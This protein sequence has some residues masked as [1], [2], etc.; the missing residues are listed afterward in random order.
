MGGSRRR[1]SQEIL[2]AYCVWAAKSSFHGACLE[3]LCR[4]SDWALKTSVEWER[5]IVMVSNPMVESYFA[6]L[7]TKLADLPRPKREEILRELRAHVWDRLE[8]ISAPIAS[9]YS[10]VLDAMGSPEEIARQYRV[11]LVLQRSAWKISPWGM[12]RTLSR[13]TLTGIQGYVVFIVALVG[14]MLGAGL[15]L[16]ALLKPLFPRN[17]GL[18]TGEYGIILASFPQ[19][20]S[21]TEIA[22]PY[23][24]P[25]AVLAGFLVMLM[26]T[27]TIRLV[28]RKFGMLKQKVAARAVSA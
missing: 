11:E 5:T 24:I 16:T 15:Y 2:L 6:A 26:T 21:G 14:Y 20:P 17:V 19:P 28:V 10:A 25:I 7:E 4:K 22:G 23:F 12:L 18:F 3:Q 27:L 1:S 8:P 13:W 9:D